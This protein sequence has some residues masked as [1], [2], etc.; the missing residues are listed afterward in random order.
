VDQKSVIQPLGNMSMFSLIRD[1]LEACKKVYFF[2]GIIC[3]IMLGALKS[4]TIK[5]LASPEYVFEILHK[6][7]ALEN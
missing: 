3:N 7:M 2:S 4:Q 1:D 6:H 5:A